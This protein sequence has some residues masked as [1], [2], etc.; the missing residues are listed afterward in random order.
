MK[1][2]LSLFILLV[3]IIGLYQNIQASDHSNDTWTVCASGCDFMT[4]A[5][6]V[7]DIQVNPGDT[8]ELANETFP[9]HDILL[10][11]DLTLVGEGQQM[12]TID[13]Q[14]L[15]RVISITQGTIITIHD[16]TITGGYILNLSGNEFG[17]GIYNNGS[18]SLH[19][20]SV[21][22]NIAELDSCGGGIFNNVLS[23][24][25]ISDSFIY[26]NE[27]INH[28]SAGGLCNGGKATINTSVIKENIG[29]G[30]GAIGN[31]GTLTITQS[32]IEGNGGG[33]LGTVSN[34]EEGTAHIDKT[35]FTENS[36]DDVI[37]NS[38]QMTI[39]NTTI[40][41]NDGGGISN[42]GDMS[43]AFTTI[44]QN[45]HYG[46]TFAATLSIENS[47]IAQNGSGDC[48]QNIPVN[49]TSLGANLT[50]DDSCVLSHP[51]DLPNT[52]PR[53]GPLADYGGDTLVHA[54][55]TGSPAIDAAVNCG[56]IAEDQ[57]GFPRPVGAACDIG[58]FEGEVPFTSFY[59]LPVA[60][61]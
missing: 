46:I 33:V 2:L 48:N 20:V 17:A 22:N 57:R 6:A 27:A 28:G 36:G 59:Y 47:I 55:L 8:L 31:G 4:I 34:G 52:Y 44:A 43:V 19:N 42:G 26:L 24:L 61:R 41:R 50:S 1:Y 12:T 7:A 60:L 13:A 40:S 30:T 11:K 15:G 10:D 45:N 29:W 51:N 58:A 3:S 54:L 38:G 39:V 37:G 32:I 25:L 23:T 16:L 56:T 18:L 35:V 49:I 9:E 14:S 21:E 53:L 5:S